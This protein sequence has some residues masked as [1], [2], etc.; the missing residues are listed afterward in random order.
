M[1]CWPVSG[2]D[3][4]ARAGRVAQIGVR[5][6]AAAFLDIHADRTG[7]VEQ[8]LVEGR[9]PDLVR[10]R[11]GA[12]GLAEVPAPGF[13]I[14]APDHGGAKLLYEACPLDGRKDTELVEMGREAGSNDSRT[15]SRGKCSR[16]KS[17]TCSPDG[18]EACGAAPR[19]ATADHDHVRRFGLVGHASLRSRFN[20]GMDEKGRP[21][22]RPFA[23]LLGPSRASRRRRREPPG[24]VGSSPGRPR[25]AL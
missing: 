7:V 5:D 25:R 15:C 11:M 4:D 6:A 14:G 8:E 21:C 17:R 10:V 24:Q 16:S 22:G 12:V 13:A 20:C 18:K 2:H 1:S 9:A 23:A 19:R 3:F